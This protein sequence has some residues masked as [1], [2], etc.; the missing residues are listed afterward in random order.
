[1]NSGASGRFVGQALA[2]TAITVGAG[3]VWTGAAYAQTV[4][5]TL[6]WES[7]TEILRR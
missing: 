4:V 5:T 7:G 6:V 2:G 1:M 3:V